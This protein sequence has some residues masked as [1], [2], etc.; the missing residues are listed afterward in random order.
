MLSCHSIRDARNLSQVCSNRC[1]G[2]TGASLTERE[3]TCTHVCRM[4]VH[5]KHRVPTAKI[6]MKGPRATRHTSSAADTPLCK[7]GESKQHNRSSY[8]AAPQQL[9]ST[10]SYAKPQNS[11]VHI[12][13]SATSLKITRTNALHD[14]N[15]RGKITRILCCSSALPCGHEYHVQSSKNASTSIKTGCRRHLHRWTAVTKKRRFQGQHAP[16]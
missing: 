13:F 14:T 16:D 7:V 9:W 4:R 12:R 6:I 3:A 11:D 5:S 2:A 1:Y 10:H 8:C 15:H